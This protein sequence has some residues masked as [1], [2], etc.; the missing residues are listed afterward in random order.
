VPPLQEHPNE[1]AVARLWGVNACVNRKLLNETIK[2]VCR[3]FCHKGQQV[4]VLK[5][6]ECRAGLDGLVGA[7]VQSPTQKLVVFG[8]ALRTVAKFQS[9][10]VDSSDMQHAKLNMSTAWPRA[11]A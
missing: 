3:A 2:I 9:N 8:D 6:N 5:K 1:L 7:R 4:K 11:L 10:L